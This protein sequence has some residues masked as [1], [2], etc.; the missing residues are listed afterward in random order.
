[1]RYWRWRT[2]EAV[3]V[4]AH[5]GFLVFFHDGGC[6]ILCVELS[7]TLLDVARPFVGDV[8]LELGG[9]AGAWPVGDHDACAKGEVVWVLILVDGSDE[10]GEGVFVDVR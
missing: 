4:E 5:E 9:F 2:E 8:G 10:V 7:V 3:V 6:V 1:M